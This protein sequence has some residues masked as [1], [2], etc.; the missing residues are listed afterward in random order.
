MN[1]KIINSNS[2]GN[3]LIVEDTILIDCGI[4]FK[5]L[6]DYYKKLEIVLLT[7]IHQDHFNKSTIR[8]LVSERPTLRF[9]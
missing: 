5:S 8:K 9:G 3:G 6:K 2:D 4:T 1:Y 7:H